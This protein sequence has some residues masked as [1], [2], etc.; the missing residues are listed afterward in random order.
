MKEQ[1]KIQLNPT[2]VIVPSRVQKLFLGSALMMW[3]PTAY[4]SFLTLKAY[5]NDGEWRILSLQIFYWLLPAVY[6]FLAYITYCRRQYR[7]PLE[8]WFMATVLGVAGFFIYQ[9]MQVLLNIFVVESRF[10]PELFVQLLLILLGLGIYVALLW[11]IDQ[12]NV[13]NRKGKK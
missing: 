1:N 4:F 9:G 11:W 10:I 7:F 3:L 8:K 2:G 13:K 6:V 5:G 12:A